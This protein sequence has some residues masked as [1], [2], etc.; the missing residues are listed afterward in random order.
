MGKQ[1]TPIK[2]YLRKP[3]VSYGA[4][5]PNLNPAQKVDPDAKGS[6]DGYKLSGD[7]PAESPSADGRL[8]PIPK[9]DAGKLPPPPMRP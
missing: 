6:A 2:H 4:D 5:D 8:R 9:L 3:G 7:L 1:K